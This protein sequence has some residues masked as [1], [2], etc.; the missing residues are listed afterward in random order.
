MKLRF[1]PPFN[2]TVWFTWLEDPGYSYRDLT[3]W[4]LE[5][6]SQG[7]L[8]QNVSINRRVGTIEAKR[9]E[10]EESHS[11]TLSNDELSEM[12]RRVNEINFQRLEEIGQVYEKDTPA[13]VLKIKSESSMVQLSV[14][15]PSMVEVLLSKRPS[16]QMSIAKWGTQNHD[17][18]SDLSEVS[19]LIR[20]LDWL[21]S[22]CPFQHCHWETNDARWIR[23]IESFHK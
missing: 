6:D 5:V 11:L 19:K 3:L 20:L 7:N 12:Q 16:E 9:E 22:K 21:L 13:C 18:K 2:E 17:F 8:V 4:R 15:L 14:Y 23:T 10:R 1:A